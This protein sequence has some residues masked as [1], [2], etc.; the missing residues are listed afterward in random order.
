MLGIHGWL[1]AGLIFTL[2]SALGACSSRVPD[3]PEP[4]D[5]VKP[6]NLAESGQ[7]VRFEFETNARNFYSGRPYVLDLEVQ[8]HGPGPGSEPDMDNVHVPF[9]LSLQRWVADAWQ[10]V[11]TSDVYQARARNLGEPLPEW[12]ASANWRYAHEVSMDTSRY[13]LSIVALPMETDA[14]YRLDVRTV[15]PTAALQHYPAQLRVHADPL[16]GK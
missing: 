10:D 12:H 13:R 1:R 6:I 2:A 3:A 4:L 5:L 7:A 9:Q 16:S 15:K 8:R 11:A 14:R